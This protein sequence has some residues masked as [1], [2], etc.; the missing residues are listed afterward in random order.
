MKKHYKDLVSYY[1]KTYSNVD[2]FEK[3]EYALDRTILWYINQNDNRRNNISEIKI[4]KEYFFTCELNE[5]SNLS[6]WNYLMYN[7]DKYN[8]QEITKHEWI[9]MSFT[10]LILIKE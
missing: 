6:T 7:G 10:R 8:I 1:K 5:F 9:S 2:W 4:W 3:S